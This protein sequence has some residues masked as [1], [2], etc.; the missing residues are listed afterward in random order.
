MKFC[1]G[2][3]L[4]QLWQNQPSLFESQ[5]VAILDHN[6]GKAGVGFRTNPGLNDG[7][8]LGFSRQTP[9]AGADVNQ[10]IAIPEDRLSGC[11]HRLPLQN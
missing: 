11:R 8:P 10:I 7:I 3:Q 9:E 2:L 6:R 4:E 5:K 1:G